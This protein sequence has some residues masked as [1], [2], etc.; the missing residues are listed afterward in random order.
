[1]KFFK[2]GFAGAF[3]L[4]NL[5]QVVR[6]DSEEDLD[7]LDDESSTGKAGEATVLTDATFKAAVDKGNPIF[8]KFYAPWCGHCKAMTA[9]WDKLAAEAP[10]EIAK[11][12]ATVE[13]ETATLMKIRG[14]PTLTL[15][16]GDAMYSYSGSRQFAA[17]KEW[18]SGGYKKDSSKSL[19]WNESIIDKAKDYATEYLQKVGQIMAYE[20]TIISLSFFL[21][22]MFSAVFFAL[23]C[24]SSKKA[25]ADVKKAAAPAK[26]AAKAE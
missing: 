12:D 20:P 1:M 22:M 18:A 24:T 19:P 21:G 15:F 13:R 17:M 9:D 2:A 3:L 10:I 25:V 8:V 26:K 14:F 23:C 11:V 4:S 16:E 6:A 7:D 5:W